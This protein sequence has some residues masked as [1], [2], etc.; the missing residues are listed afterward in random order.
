[1]SD[2]KTLPWDA[3]GWRDEVHAWIRVVLAREKIVLTGEIVQEHIRQWS[4]VLTV[5]TDAGMLYFKAAAPA[6]HH[7]SALTNALARWESS[8]LPALLAVDVEKSWL[9]MRSSGTPLRTF[10]KEEQS[11][12]RWKPILNDYVAFQK[13][14]ADLGEVIR[15]VV[16]VREVLPATMTVNEDRGA[17]GHALL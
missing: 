1:M 9:L 4:T 13:R 15:V 10:I 6:L 17:E 8:F 12:R 11:L 7:E 2:K 5:P 16:N 3:V 14:L